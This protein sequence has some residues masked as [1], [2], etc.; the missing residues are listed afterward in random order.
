MIDHVLHSNSRL[1]A[2]VT[3]YDREHWLGQ[4]IESLM[5]QSRPAED[6]VVLD[7]ASPQPPLE[8]VRQFPQVTLLVAEENVGPYRLLQQIFDRTDYDGFLLQDSDD[9]SSSDRLALL[10]EEA[11]RTGAAVLGT[12]VLEILCAQN[13]QERLVWFP[14]DANAA[15][16]VDPT[17]HHMMFGTALISR[18]VIHHVGGLASGLRYGADSEFFRRARHIA[19]MANIQHI[20]YFRRRHSSALTERPDTGLQSPARQRLQR[21]LKKRARADAEAVRRGQAPDLK[22]FAAAPPIQLRHLLG[23]ELRWTQHKLNPAFG[24]SEAGPSELGAT[25]ANGRAH[26]RPHDQL[27]ELPLV[28]ERS[29]ANTIGC[30]PVCIA[31]M[32]RSGTSMVARL[33]NLCG[34]YLGQPAELGLAIPSNPEGHWENSRFLVINEEILN[35][36]GGAWDLPPAMEPDWEKRPAMKDLK[37]D[38]QKLLEGFGGYQLWGWKDPRNSLTLPFWKELLPGLK[39]IVCLRHPLEV[40]F[41]L[42]ARGVSSYAFGL[43]LWRQYYQ[44]IAQATPSEERIVTHYSAFFVSPENELRRLLGHIGLKPSDSALAQCKKFINSGLRHHQLHRQDLFNAEVE[45]DLIERYT[46]WCAEAGI[47]AEPT[48]SKPPDCVVSSLLANTLERHLV[49]GPGAD[50]RDSEFAVPPV[51]KLMLDVV[52]SQRQIAALWADHD[53]SAKRISELEQALKKSADLAAQQTRE[54]AELKEVRDATVRPSAGVDQT[55]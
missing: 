30:A 47:T 31:G 32:H 37:L 34:L 6:I 15:Y 24:A 50:L 18:E 25:E 51:N 36:L 3:H 55:Q 48:G 42:R 8:V 54:L 17:G 11:Q 52:L 27:S 19:R 38:A 14:P 44:R 28:S 7:D 35:R 45:L 13:N 40:A 41:S 39:V 53:R 5:Q 29:Q 1:L 22:P 26:P 46:D 16:D 10:L 12:Q 20:C 43:S 2:V 33:L 21:D 4:C 23:P 9:W 49:R